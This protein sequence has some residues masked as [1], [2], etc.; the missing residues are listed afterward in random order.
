MPL[1]HADEDG[2]SSIASYKTEAEHVVGIGNLAIQIMHARN[3]DL[4]T[5][6]CGLACLGKTIVGDE[7]NART[8]LAQYLLALARELDPDASDVRWQ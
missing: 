7:P 4:V 1:E 5:V 8:I 2:S 6:A 3:F